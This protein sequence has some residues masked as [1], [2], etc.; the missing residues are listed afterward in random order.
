MP[1]RTDIHKVLVIG[2]GPIVIGQA[3]EFDYSGTQAIKALREEGVRG[4]PP[5]QQPGHGDDRSGVR[6]PDL[7]RADH[8]RGRR[9]DHRARAAGRAAAHHG[10]PDRAQPGQGARRERHPRTL[11]REAHRRLA[12][13]HQQGRGPAALQ[14]GD[15]EDR[16]RRCPGAATR[17]S[18]DEAKAIVKDIGFPA[19]IRPSFT[20][21]GTGGGV[22]YNRDEFEAICRAGAEGQPHLHAPGRGVAC[23]G[24]RSSSWR[25]SA[26]RRTTSSSSAPS[27]TW[28]RWAC[29]PATRITV[30][31]AQTLTD[32]EYQRLRQASL[33]H[34]PRD[35]RRHRRV[36]HPVRRRTRRT[37]AWWSSR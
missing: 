32:K 8:R 21:G 20:L 23:S 1:K 25:W 29:T 24:G 12:R 30:A 26:T 10:R 14:G 22:A 27:R 7:H 3:C 37:A 31:P 35:R 9:A 33:R 4:R 17:T 28:T 18:L 6:P 36:Q 19:I 15:A 16:R 5:Q 2:S 11:R 13:G 34:H